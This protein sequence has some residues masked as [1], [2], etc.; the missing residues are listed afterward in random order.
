MR[1]RVHCVL[2]VQSSENG[3]PLRHTFWTK[4][5]VWRLRGIN[6]GHRW[7]SK[8]PLSERLMFIMD[9]SSSPLT[10]VALWPTSTSKE[11]QAIYIISISI[12]SSNYPN[13]K[14]HL[15]VKATARPQIFDQAAA[16]WIRLRWHLHTSLESILLITL[17]VKKLISIISRK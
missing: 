13:I 10:K 8:T 11:E 14:Y 1:G 7:V 4:K 9:L 15:L 16:I 3:T 12:A 2:V 5:M 6:I 17:S